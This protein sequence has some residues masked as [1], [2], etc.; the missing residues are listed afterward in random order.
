MSIIVSKFGGSSTANAD[1]FIKIQRI[2]ESDPRRRY[3]VLS[4]PGVFPGCREKITNLLYECHSHAASG[5]DYS[6]SLKKI[7]YRFNEIAKR[8]SIE[9]RD[10]IAE[11]I[12]AYL[13]IS[14][15]HTA[16]RGEY[17]CAKLFS[18]WSNI[19]F[20]D[21]CGLIA[22][23]AF[24][25][26]CF[27]KTMRNFR[28]MASSLDQAIIPGFYGAKPDGSIHT[29]SRNG[30]DISGA[31]AAVGVGASLYE[32]WSDVDGF[33]SADPS[34][35]PDAKLNSQ[36]SYRQMSSLAEAGAQVLHPECLSP[37]A[38]A[39]IPTNLKNTLNPDHPG[40]MITNDFDRIV[41]CVTGKNDY[42]YLPESGF[43]HE[44]RNRLTFI[45]HRLHMTNDGEEIALAKS[46]PLLEHA[47]EFV[48]VACI[49]IFGMT[50][51][52]QR[53]SIRLLSPIAAI[54]EHYHFKML[55]PPDEFEDTVR[56]LHGILMNNIY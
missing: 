30:S 10:N 32:N 17:L 5:L 25:Q 21:A 26:L 23:D 31:L 11:E 20:A 6:D 47:D 40:T 55:V 12:A 29:F 52:Q 1:M 15:D 7:V 44:T 54:D 42:I 36:V 41:P 19:P 43:N 35:V 34:I 4:A 9:Y 24:G 27:D 56:T 13:Q 2:L 22:F 38:R 3:I 37:V 51:E 53:A 48:H 16:S 14:S 33:M 49:S 45:P 39:N 46:H 28:D 18:Q 50:A 8:L